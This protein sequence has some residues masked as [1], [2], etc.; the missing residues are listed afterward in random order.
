MEKLPP[1]L[2]GYIADFIEQDPLG[3]DQQRTLSTL[4]RTNKTLHEICNPRIYRNPLLR[5]GRT[6]MKWGKVYA[7]FVNPWTICAGTQRLEDVVVPRSITFHHCGEEDLEDE[8]EDSAPV[9]NRLEESLNV[10]LGLE[11]EMSPFFLRHLTSFTVP[12]GDCW[13]QPDFIARLVGPIGFNRTTIKE[14]SLVGSIQWPF[15]P[16]FLE[17]LYRM[18]WITVVKYTPSLLES[19]PHDSLSIKARSALISFLEGD[20]EILDYDDE[21]EIDDTVRDLASTHWPMFAYHETVSSEADEVLAEILVNPPPD[22]LLHPLTSLENLTIKI[23]FALELYL[24]FHSRLFPSLRRL[25][26]I[27]RIGTSSDPINDVKLFRL[28]V[29]QQVILGCSLFPSAFTEPRL[30]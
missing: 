3:F 12:E 29:T 9:S 5:D 27:G 11:L 15:V 18:E 13:T 2:L 4:A 30:P 17:A 7:Q 16:F 1:E 21:D 19:F 8:E 23:R 25:K 20:E 14:L 6:A 28:S 24:I 26:V 22:P 10:C